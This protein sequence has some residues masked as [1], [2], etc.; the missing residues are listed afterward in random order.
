MSGRELFYVENSE[1]KRMALGVMVLKYGDITA[2]EVLY[3]DMMLL[4]EGY[5]I[6]S[7]IHYM[8][9]CIIL[10]FPTTRRICRA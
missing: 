3:T 1:I 9:T 7:L 2:L 5:S 8:Y 6:E 10:I 4:D